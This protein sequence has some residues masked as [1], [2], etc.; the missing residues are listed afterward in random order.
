MMITKEDIF[1]SPDNFVWVFG[2]NLDRTGYGGQA[3][4]ARQFVY[5]GK[6]FGIPTKR[7]PTA[8]HDAYFSDRPEEMVAVNDSIASL[9][10]LVHGGKHLV[11]FPGVGEGY[12]KLAEKSPKIYK[13]LKESIRAFC[14][15]GKGEVRKG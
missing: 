3:A 4:V 14:H 7:H 9:L 5:R 2:D 13:M 6:A 12:A 8:E 11:F 1:N 15:C 10:A